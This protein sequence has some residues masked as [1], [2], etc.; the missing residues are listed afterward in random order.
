MENEEW[1]KLYE[2]VITETARNT[3]KEEPQCFNQIKK[4]FKNV[5]EIK[6]FLKDRYG[7]IPKIRENN[8]IYV[9]TKDGKTNMVGFTYSFWNR[10]ISHNSKAWY[11]TDW[12]TI[13]ETKIKHAD[14]S[15]FERLNK[16]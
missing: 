1:T 7:K 4:V 9:D 5:E 16:N 6:A 3:L 2:V 8:K 11:Q 12:I 13:D 10:D 15:V 14:P